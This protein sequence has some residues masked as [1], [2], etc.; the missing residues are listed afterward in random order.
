MET[1]IMCNLHE[2]IPDF[3]NISKYGNSNDVIINT[4]YINDDITYGMINYNKDNLCPDTYATYGLARSIITI[5]G[6][7]KCFS[8][9]KAIEYQSFINLYPKSDDI[10]V[11]E[12]VEGTMI[13]VFWDNV[14]NDWKINTRKRIGANNFFYTNKQKSLTFKQMFEDIISEYDNF[15]L[16]NL[17]K[18]YCYSFI[19]QHPDNRIVI[20]VSSKKLYLIA[21]YHIED[22]EGETIINTINLNDFKNTPHMINTNI[23]YPFVYPSGWNSYDEL[24]VNFGTSVTPSTILGVVIRNKTNNQRC[25]IRN[26]QY[27][28]IRALKGNQSNIIYNYLRLRK[29]NQVKEYLEHYSDHAEEFSNF[30][31]KIHKFTGLLYSKYIDCYIKKQKPLKEYD[32][33]FRTHMYKLHKIYT[34]VLKPDNKYMNKKGVIEYVNNLDSKLLMYSLGYSKNDDDKLESSADTVL[35]SLGLDPP[36]NHVAT[37]F[38][39][40]PNHAIEAGIHQCDCPIQ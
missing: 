12:M 23:S 8:P 3:D 37:G 19:I 2:S 7:V 16:D 9:P 35:P 14:N 36:G 4:E 29:E 28:T 18:S 30:R 31:D 20:P 24:K 21:V 38:A 1:I 25:K 26:P 11:E 10:I 15:S 34:T 13:N 33:Y 32:E 40:E 17:N 6:S 5:D 22:I 39:A 27:E